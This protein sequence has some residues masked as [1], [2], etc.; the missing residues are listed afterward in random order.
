[1]TLTPTV[2][3]TIELMYQTGWTDGLPVVPPT[4]D[5][6]EDFIGA[7]G[8]QGDELIAELP[9][10]GGR[11][12]VVISTKEG[13]FKVLEDDGSGAPSLHWSYLPPERD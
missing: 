9:P 2:A 4:G 8:R 5:L 7:S 1:M 12:T 11:A 6:V 13:E 3:D 10:L